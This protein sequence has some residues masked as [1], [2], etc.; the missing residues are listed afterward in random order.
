MNLLAVNAGI[1]IGVVVGFFGLLILGIIFFKRK[2]LKNQDKKPEEKEI[3]Q[4]E[5]NRVLEEVNDEE[6]LKAMKAFE[7]KQKEE[8]AKINQ[9]IEN[10]GEQK[11]NK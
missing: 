3:V 8:S 10:N 5:L 1:I 9:N 11:D 2:V 4:Q 6:T 7:E